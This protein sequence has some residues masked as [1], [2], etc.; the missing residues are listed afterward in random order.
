MARN[1]RT[2]ISNTKYGFM[3]NIGQQLFDILNFIDISD[4]KECM[5]H[6]SFVQQLK[7]MW[8]ATDSDKY[9]ERNSKIIT[10]RIIN[11][12]VQL[13]ISEEIETWLCE[14][15]KITPKS[16]QYAMDFFRGKV[17][18]QLK[19]YDKATEYLKKSYTMNKDFFCKQE[20]IFLKFINSDNKPG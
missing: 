13:N 4:K 7:E 14:L 8:M 9:N 16:P 20:Q 18:F 5:D 6:L 3:K 1:L 11:E 12:L 15:D 10:V 2:E 19:E 17:Y